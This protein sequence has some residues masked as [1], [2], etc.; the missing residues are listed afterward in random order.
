MTSIIERHYNAYAAADLTAYLDT[1][2]FENDADRWRAERGFSSSWK[3][4]KLQRPKLHFKNAIQSKTGEHAVAH[5]EVDY[6]LLIVDAGEQFPKQEEIFALLD[7]VDNSWKIRRIIAVSDIDDVPQALNDHK[8]SIWEQDVA[9]IKKLLAFDPAST[10]LPSVIS[11]SSTQS[12]G[13]PVAGHGPPANLP[14][15]SGPMAVSSASGSVILDELPQQD[16]T[17]G[18]L[19]SYDFTNTLVNE[20][21]EDLSGNGYIG[22]LN[23]PVWT[24]PSGLYFDGQDDYVEVEGGEQLHSDAALTVIGEFITTSYTKKTWQNLVW[25]GNAPDGKGGA[26]DCTKNCENRE[27]TLWLNANAHLHA[28]STAKDGVGQGQTLVNTPGGSVAGKT[29]FAQ[30]IDSAAERMQVYINGQEAASQTYSASGLRRTDGPLLIGGGGPINKGWSFRGYLRWLRIYDRALSEEEIAA[31]TLETTPEPWRD[32]YALD[33]AVVKGGWATITPIQDDPYFAR[34]DLEKIEPGMVIEDGWFSVP[35]RRQ[36]TEIVYRH[37]GSHLRLAGHA[38]VLDCLDYC[39]LGGLVEQII[40]GD[41]RELWHSGKISHQGTGADFDI[42]L[43]GV[44]EIRL[45]TTDGG[46]GDGEDW[47]AWLN[48]KLSRPDPQVPS[49]AA[50]GEPPEAPPTPV[51]ISDSPAT[52]GR[53]D[54]VFTFDQKPEETNLVS[55][56]RFAGETEEILVWFLYQDLETGDVLTGVWTDIGRQLQL[57]AVPVVVSESQGA[58]GFSLRRPVTGWSRGK[59][60]VAIKKDGKVLN[61]AEFHIDD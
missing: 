50:L 18:L 15:T 6:H 12:P 25:K 19:L 28:T 11:T 45:V 44:R 58:A 57:R 31:I 8:L 46:N 60:Q 13:T 10:E 39:G 41:G 38:T 34:L 5:F 54:S 14:L 7:F 32:P 24:G 42:D 55:M 4:V 61:S 26:S 22:K 23:G 30:V 37:D 47:A 59:Y 20:M 2:L 35:T 40:R 9:R 27:F 49:P 48:L 52:I 51:Q 21:V 36:E 3:K 16:I 29:V 43:T 53:V 1:L 17:S 33:D 56:T